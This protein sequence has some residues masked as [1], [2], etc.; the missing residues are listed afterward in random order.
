MEDPKIT[1][2]KEVMKVLH[3]TLT[4]EEFLDAFRNVVEYVKKIKVDTDAVIRDTQ[5]KSDKAIG[6]KIDKVLRPYFETMKKEH[7]DMLLKISSVKDGKDADEDL[8]IEKVLA[9][10]PQEDEMLE[11]VLSKLPKPKEV[12]LDGG[13]EI[14]DKINELP[15]E[16]EYQI[17]AKHIKNLPTARG[18]NVYGPGKTKI[19]LLDLSAQ[20]DGSTKTFPIGTHFGI[21]GVFGSSTPFAFRPIID[22]TESGQN[23]VF[24]SGIDA[25]SMLASGQTLVIQYLK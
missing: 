22:Y 9:E 8:I 13:K 25:A 7:Q 19:I 12:V 20:L 6:T 10:I 3:G 24:A 23:I 2:L 18:G 1:K 16:P 4:K 15:V 14:V 21:I 5:S 17:D 11:Y